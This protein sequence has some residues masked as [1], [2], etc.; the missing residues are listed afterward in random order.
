M[1]KLLRRWLW[2]AHTDGD[3][4]PALFSQAHC[5][6]RRCGRSKKYPH[7]L[8]STILDNTDCDVVSVSVDDTFR[9]LTSASSPPPHFKLG[10]FLNCDSLTYML[11]LMLFFKDRESLGMPSEA[12]SPVIRKELPPAPI[13]ESDPMPESDPPPYPIPSSSGPVRVNFLHLEQDKRPIEDSWTVD[14]LLSIPPALMPPPSDDKTEETANLSLRNTHKPIIAR[15]HL[16]SDRPCKSRIVV[17]AKHKDATVTIVSACTTVNLP[18]IPWRTDRIRMTRSTVNSNH[19]TF[20][21][22]LRTDRSR[23]L[24]LET[25][26]VRSL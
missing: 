26:E 4:N 12:E 2:D 5:L 8:K 16:V 21:S 11:A 10:H 17:R 13:P 24:F 6:Q 1:R 20:T 23:S 15:L 9:R 3:P 25:S 7:S 19:F 22:N 18:S 14:P